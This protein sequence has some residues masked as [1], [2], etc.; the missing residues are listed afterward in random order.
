LRVE[1]DAV[2]FAAEAGESFKDHDGVAEVGAISRILAVGIAGPVDVLVD[3]GGG[4]D[5]GVVGEEGEVGSVP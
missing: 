3:E 5:G 2:G 1:K 4:V